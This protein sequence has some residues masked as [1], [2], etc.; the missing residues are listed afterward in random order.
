MKNPF[1]LYH[2][3][4]LPTPD[5]RV[6]GA[7]MPP[8]AFEKQIAFLRD[9]GFTFKTAAEITDLKTRT[10]SFPEKT[11]A[12]TFDDG[13]RDNYT[14]AFPIL[15]KYRVSATIFLVTSCI[16]TTSD[17]VTAE[18]EAP[19]R[20][21][22]PSDIREMAEFGIE[23]GS[24]TVDHVHLHQAAP[25]V[26]NRQLVDSRRIISDLTGQECRTLAYPAGFYNS[27][28]AAAAEAAGYTAAFTTI[29]GP[30]TPDDP[31]QLN[32]VEILRRDRFLFRFGR[33][34]RTDVG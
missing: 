27:D 33:K 21:L 13:W 31:F 4:D 29:Y 14:N 10:G 18:G 25:D 3:I 17:M 11:V 34:I 30:E 9:R 6:R 19:R 32:R 24:H 16:G 1:L 23:F 15:K 26:V 8:R 22:D 7:Y 28:V 20:H 12:L 5:V 2:K